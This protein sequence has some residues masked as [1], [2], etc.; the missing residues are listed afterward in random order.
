MFNLSSVSH[1]HNNACERIVIPHSACETCNLIEIQR[2]IPTVDALRTA[3]LA[4]NSSND[5]ETSEKREA[6][7]IES[8][9]GKS[10]A[11]YVA[12]IARARQL[13]CASRVAS[14]IPTTATAPWQ[15]ICIISRMAREL[16]LGSRDRS[17]CP[18]MGFS[19]QL[20]VKRSDNDRSL[21]RN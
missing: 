8:I 6:I 3:A 17:L 11:I 4:I 10:I 15:T 20:G 5:S 1:A 9:I 19:I 21:V 16:L 13:A 14:S 18:W 12:D 7:C 2:W